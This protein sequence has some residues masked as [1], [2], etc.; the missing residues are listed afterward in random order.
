[1]LDVIKHKI[2]NIATTYSTP[3]LMSAE[4]RKVAEDIE[5]YQSEDATATDLHR[6]FRALERYATMYK[7]AV[8]EYLAMP[9][10]DLEKRSF[11][12]QEILCLLTLITSLIAG[13]LRKY[14]TGDDKGT[15]GRH[16][17]TLSNNLE[18]YKNDKISW[19]T[20]LKAVTTMVEERIVR[21]RERMQE[22]ITVKAGE[23]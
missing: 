21:R 1:M 15:I 22:R 2:I 6:T 8:E 23:A 20:M 14:S 19:T 9:T 7:V 18:Q 12:L 3:E 4:L 13:T 17:R 10:K 11:Q 16:V 5:K